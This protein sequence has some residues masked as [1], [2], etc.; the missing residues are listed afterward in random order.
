MDGSR[1]HWTVFASVDWWGQVRT[2]VSG[3]WDLQRTLKEHD[4]ILIWP[5]CLGTALYWEKPAQAITLL[6]LK[7]PVWVGLSA[8]HRFFRKD[9]ISSHED[10]HTHPIRTSRT[11]PFHSQNYTT[12]IQIPA[13][14][15]KHVS[16]DLSFNFFKPQCP[17]LLFF[18]LKVNNY[19]CS[20][21]LFGTSA[22]LKALGR[23]PGTEKMFSECLYHQHYH[24]HH[25]QHFDY[26]QNSV[27]FC[28]SH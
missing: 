18:S 6:G 16:L 3:K 1:S 20:V 23:E 8:Q 4:D 7:V 13:L 17:Y 22:I 9:L 2:W 19:P 24:H 12:Q 5:K 11:Y 26:P 25:H 10:L 27:P 28:I 14:P 15:L 21:V